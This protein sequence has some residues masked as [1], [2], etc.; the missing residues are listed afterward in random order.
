VRGRGVGGP[1]G[2]GVGRVGGLAGTV[3]GGVVGAGGEA[4]DEE[5][6]GEGDVDINVAVHGVFGEQIDAELL[7]RLGEAPLAVEGEDVGEDAAALV[8]MDEFEELARHGGRGGREG[9]VHSAAV[10]VV[11]ARVLVVQG[12]V[13]DAAAQ[14]V[15]GEHAGDEG[16]E[17]DV[18]VV[19]VEWDGA[20]ELELVGWEAGG[21]WVGASVVRAL[22]RAEGE[23]VTYLYCS[24]SL[25][26]CS[27]VLVG[28]FVPANLPMSG[29]R[30]W[31]H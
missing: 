23:G 9:A 13:E 14:A 31:V 10:V 24:V 18:A 28:S 19:E 6:A 15:R 11:D 21:G 25:P 30:C 22:R 5:L 16:L 2:D 26:L 20:A 27:F 8:E 29:D 12:A 4:A 1:V 7:A 17:F 3:V